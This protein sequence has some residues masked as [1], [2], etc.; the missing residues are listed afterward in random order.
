MN[1]R[2][3]RAV[4]RKEFLHIV[5]DPRSLAMAL[6]MPLMMLFL[7][8]YALTLDVD[9]IPTVVY[10]SDYTPESRELIQ[11]FQGSRYFQILG[12]VDQYETIERKIDRDQC[13]LGVV[14]PQDYSRKLLSGD[15]AEIQIL[16]DGSDSNTASIALG[17]AESMLQ[18][19]GLELRAVAFNRKGGGHLVPPIEPRLRVWYNSEL[20]SK[21]YIV[22]GLIAVILMII[23][24][25]LTSLTIARE[26]EMGTMEQLLSTPLRPAEMVLGKMVAFFGV[27]LVDMVLAIAVGVLIFQVPL[28]GNPLFL[29]FTG[30]VFLFGGLCWGILISAVARSQLLAYQ[31]GMLSSFLPAFV[32]SGFIYSIENMP[33]VIRVI[34]HVV[35]ARYFVTILKGVFLKGIGFEVLW[36]EVVFLLTFA[37]IVFLLA[38]R[39]LK[40]KL[41]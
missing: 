7:F 21:N 30:C 37:G 1:T 12:S 27:G 3:T 2:R 14:I 25:L 31:M 28:R 35:P 13:L 8:G 34:T 22:P 36:A 29:F 16:L 15:E 6:G 10:D 41:A 33:V 24:A 32:L 9:R 38:T 39:K 11:R 19:Y 40:Q 17:Y 20:K 23:A 26:W 4:A 5:R 18:R